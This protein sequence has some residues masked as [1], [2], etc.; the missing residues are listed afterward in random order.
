MFC[1]SQWM[2]LVLNLE[3]H[4]KMFLRHQTCCLFWL[5]S[6]PLLLFCPTH[7]CFNRGAP[8]KAGA[9]II[10]V[11]PE[12]GN[13]CAGSWSIFP[14]VR[15]GGVHKKIICLTQGESKALFLQALISGV[16]N[17]SF[18]IILCAFQGWSIVPVLVSTSLKTLLA[19]KLGISDI[20]GRLWLTTWPSKQ[21]L[22]QV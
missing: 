14:Q 18:V 12:Q 8:V 19:R 9:E 22:S 5:L 20:S 21:V 3:L 11:E 2:D 15:R 13:S 16:C 1:E 4:N 6:V 17:T 7:S 10:P